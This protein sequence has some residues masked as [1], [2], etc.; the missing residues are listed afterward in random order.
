MRRA[1]ENASV[2][3]TNYMADYSFM[4]SGFSTLAEPVRSTWSDDD[5]NVAQAAL[6]VFTED[7]MVMAKE[8]AAL[9]GHSEVTVQDIVDCLKAKTRQ[10]VASSPQFM[11]RIQEYKS[12]LESMPSGE[13]SSGS[14]ASMEDHEDEEEESPA[15]HMMH[16]LEEGHNSTAS[17]TETGNAE[18]VQQV[19][20]YL[21]SWDDWE[22]QNDVEMILKQAVN[23]TAQA[24]HNHEE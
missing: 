4:R 14:E 7:S 15:E 19:R 10:G 11:E 23:N 12:I 24:F 18:L 2:V 8:Y 17:A 16:A 21:S 3:V 20:S 9:Q 22:P 6:L 5:W 1:E 13:D